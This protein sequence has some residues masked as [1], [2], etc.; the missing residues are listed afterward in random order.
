MLVHWGLIKLARHVDKGYK[1]GDFVDN[2]NILLGAM[3]IE[4]P[5]FATHSSVVLMCF[6]LAMGDTFVKRLILRIINAWCYYGYVGNIA[7][8]LSE[9][10]F[11]VLLAIAEELDDE[12][13]QFFE[14]LY[15][16]F[17]EGLEP[18]ADPASV[19]S[20]CRSVDQVAVTEVCR[21]ACVLKGKCFDRAGL[22]MEVYN[23]DKQENLRGEVSCGVASKRP[24]TRG[25]I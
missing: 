9:D 21:L 14:A 5:H 23:N 18:G 16:A 25:V 24:S 3:G 1:S 22:V 8:S 11:V 19:D 15:R 10:L 4:R 20:L 7:P 12:V 17:P 2:I 6:H 13:E